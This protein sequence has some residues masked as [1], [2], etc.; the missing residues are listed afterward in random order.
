MAGQ[1]CPR[2]HGSHVRGSLVGCKQVLNITLGHHRRLPRA[3]ARIERNVPVQ[4]QPKPLAVVES[5]HQK[6]PPLY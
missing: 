4:V 2:P 6:S 1:R 5:N 3:C